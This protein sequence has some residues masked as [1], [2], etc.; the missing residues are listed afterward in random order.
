M[1]EWGRYE[2][3]GPVARCFTVSA[4][5]LPWCSLQSS[6]R[7]WGFGC[8]FAV[9]A[10]MGPFRRET[11][12]QD[13]LKT[14]AISKYVSTYRD[15]LLRELPDEAKVNKNTKR[16]ELLRLGRCRFSQLP[17]S[18][19]DQYF[20]DAGRKDIVESENV[21]VPSSSGNSGVSPLR[22]VRG[23]PSPPRGPPGGSPPRASLKRPSA[24]LEEPSPSWIG[25]SAPSEGVVKNDEVRLAL[26]AYLGVLQKL[27][28]DADG[29]AAL[30]T[31]HRLAAGMHGFKGPVRVKAAAILSL[32]VKMELTVKNASIRRL[33]SRVAGERSIEQVKAMEQKLFECF[34][35]EGV[36]GTYAQE[37]LSMLR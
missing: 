17:K 30:A 1:E 23:P 22:T 31:S 32:A 12:I 20:K 36:E 16:S 24:F 27:F 35:L 26:A 25:T 6:S 7:V 11:L 15:E 14:A 10:A 9:D 4:M 18:E 28:G 2:G 8:A 19:Q 13:R 33:W 21:A 3:G 37:R 5:Y 29:L 34:A